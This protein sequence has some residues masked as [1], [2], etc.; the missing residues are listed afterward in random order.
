M[1][2]TPIDPTSVIQPALD[3]V[4][5]GLTGVAG[6][7]LLVGGGLLAIRVGWKFVKGFAR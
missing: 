2:A 1:P 5:N 6:P 7:A 4:Q 3:A